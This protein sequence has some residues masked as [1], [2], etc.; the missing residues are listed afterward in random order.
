MVHQLGWGGAK[1][2]LVLSATLFSEHP[3]GGSNGFGTVF[4]VNADGT[5]FAVLHP[6][7]GG[8]DGAV[9]IKL[10][11][12]GNTLYGLVGRGTN[13]AVTDRCFPWIPTAAIS[14]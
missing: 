5:G 11:L 9:Q 1:V 6:F 4:S 7:T 8:S 3:L 2:D 10:V 12:S 14:I 13:L